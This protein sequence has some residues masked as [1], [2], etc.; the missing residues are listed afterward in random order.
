MPNVIEMMAIIEV[1][2]EHMTL[3]DQ[4][5]TLSEIELCKMSQKKCRFCY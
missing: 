1:V 4:K 5:T 2:S 3:F